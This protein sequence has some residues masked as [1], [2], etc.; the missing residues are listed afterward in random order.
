MLPIRHA[1]KQLVAAW[2]AGWLS[3]FAFAASAADP[4]GRV[5]RITLIEG[6][7]KF[8]ADQEDG[9]EAARLNVPVTSENSIWAEGR[10]R[11]EWRVGPA[12]VRLDHDTVLDVQKLDD[13]EVVLYVQRGAANIRVGLI[14]KGE[15]FRI[16]TPEGTVTL[17]ARGSYRIEADMDKG[18]SRV[19][20]LSGRARI[21]SSAGTP[22]IEAGRMAVLDRSSVRVEYIARTEFDDW[23]QVR[24]EKWDVAVPADVSPYMTGYE[25]LNHHGTWEEESEYGR[26]WVPRVVVDWAPYRYGHWRHV[27]PWGWTWIDDAPWGFAP[28]HYGR[29]VHVRGRWAW[30][31]GNRIHRPIWSP[32]LV[33]WVGGSGWSVTYSTGSGPGIGWFPLAPYEAYVP[34]YRHSPNYVYNI[35]HIHRHRPVPTRPPRHYANH[36]PGVTVVSPTT[37]QAALPVATHRGRMPG[38]A[39]WNQPVVQDGVKLPPRR[40]GPSL[41]HNP[42]APSGKPA[43]LQPAAAAEPLPLPHRTEERIGT[44]RPQKPQPVVGATP[45]GPKPGTLDGGTWNQPAERMPS[46]PAPQPD[47]LPPSVAQPPSMPA[48][49]QGAPM[50]MPVQRA[51]PQPRYTPKPRTPAESTQTLPQPAPVTREMS[52]AY[53]RTPRPVI[54][55]DRPERIERIERPRTVDTAPSRPAPAAQ[56]APAPT[57]PASRPKPAPRE[58]KDREEAPQA[59]RIKNPGRT[60]ER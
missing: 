9:W 50:P 29:W 48:A 15:V 40:G 43:I 12:A 55:N 51:E 31:P 60:P 36:K 7:V 10:S 26:I 47:P 38:E 53:D 18:E 45:G 39:I 56:P 24:D 14:E 3:L 30:W 57:Q 34:W 42:A 2:L 8:Y 32:A 41:A 1:M 27:R 22:W 17:R 52:P 46:R 54:R 6:T 58:T 59:E 35:N 19:A 11:A 25:E 16:F 23:A 44:P 37:F 28:M 20:V 13:T 5:G 21:E 33:A 4:P 49:N